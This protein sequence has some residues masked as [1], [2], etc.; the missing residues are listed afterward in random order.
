MASSTLNTKG[1]TLYSLR[2]TFAT[3]LAFRAIETT[4]ISELL[5]HSHNG[6]TMGR[7]VKG[8]PIKL[9]SEAI[10]KLEPI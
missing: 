6:M 8:L 9:L 3:E 2:H 7:Y 4:I 10:N 1:K 5:G